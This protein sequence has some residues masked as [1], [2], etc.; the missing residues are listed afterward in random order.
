MHSHN[1][2][3]KRL[4]PP[5]EKCFHSPNNSPLDRHKTHPTEPS[6]PDSSLGRH[7]DLQNQ[8]LQADNN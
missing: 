3:Q 1:P 4:R 7:G 8:K 2:K 5:P 6:K